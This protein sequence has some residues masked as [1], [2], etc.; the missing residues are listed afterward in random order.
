MLAGGLISVGLSSQDL[1]AQPTVINGEEV[2]VLEKENA[3]KVKQVWW[4]KLFFANIQHPLHDNILEERFI[5]KNGHNANSIEMW[6]ET[7]LM[8][9]FNS[10][11]RY[12]ASQNARLHVEVCFGINRFRRIAPLTNGVVLGDFATPIGHCGDGGV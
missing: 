1:D 12:D 9:T 8:G 11:L 5:F 4:P 6:Y 2:H 3:Y 7:R 10:G